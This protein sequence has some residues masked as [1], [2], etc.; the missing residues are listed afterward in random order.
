VSRLPRRLQPIWPVVKRL[1]RLAT[2]LLGV[3]FRRTSRLAGGRA[4][5][6]RAT[7]RSADLAALDPRRVGV[8]TGGPAEVL[9]R[10]MPVGEPA[11]HAAFEPWL[12]RRVSARYVLDVRGG[13]L[14]GDYAATIAPGG[15]LDYET[16][17]YFGISGWREHPLFL[18]PRLPAP[19]AVPGTLLSLATRGTSTNYYHF[20]TDLLPRWGIFQEACPGTEVDAVYLSTR[21]SY[22]RQLLAL[23]GLDS[24]PVVEV[25]K[26]ACLAPD[27]L[28]VPS[29]PNQDLMA[30]H[31]VVD[32]LRTHL[33]ASPDLGERARGLYVTRG[34]TPNTRRYVEEPDLWPAL[35]ARG[36]ARL[37]PGTVSVQEQ[38]DA[39]AAAEVVVAPHGAALANLVFARPGVRVLELF[40]PDYVN[41]CYWA[42]TQSIPDAS[43]RYLVAGTADE[44]AAAEHRPM[45][46]VLR[47]VSIPPERV[48]AALDRLLAGPGC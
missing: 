45:T 44:I 42:I 46:G 16:S 8:H 39:F 27:R 41:P 14:V 48:L 32:W 2:W 22:Q 37:D 17:G 12:R 13:L 1:H 47:D 43:Y 30:P 18:R 40:A 15:V 9:V 5:P 33:P 21:S 3:V 7:E 26:H 28:L 6:T 25:E 19:T 23:V 38:I 10:T 4:L 36:F 34:A 11:G 24:L 20:L 29:T 31:W 35:E